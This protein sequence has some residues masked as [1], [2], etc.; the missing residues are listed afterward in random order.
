MAKQDLVVKLLLDSG[1][2]GNDIREAERKAKDFSDNM[3]SAG[4]TVG[5]FGNEL[6]LATGVLGK[7]G[8]MLTG[9]GAVVAA[10]GA[11]KSIMESTNESSM[12]FKSSIAGFE[13]VLSTFQQSLANF[14]FSTWLNGM[15]EVFRRHKEWKQ[16]QMEKELSGI[17][18]NALITRDEARIKEL[19]VKFNYAAS[20]SEREK[21]KK[22]ALGVVGEMRKVADNFG[23]AVSDGLISAIERL[24]PKLKEGG[25]TGEKADSLIWEALKK[26]NDRSYG[27][28]I[29]L[30]KQTAGEI[31]N[32][33]HILSWRGG[34]ELQTLR[35]NNIGGGNDVIIAEYEKIR[36]NKDF[37]RQR[38]TELIDSN[39]ELFFINAI[40]KMVAKEL[41]AE[42]SDMMNA[43]QQGKKADELENTILKWN[44]STG[45]GTSGNTKQTN[46]T[47]QTKTNAKLEPI[48]GSFADKQKEL[49]ELKRQ[50]DEDVVFESEKWKQ[51]TES[52]IIAEEALKKMLETQKQ[53]ENTDIINEDSIGYIQQQIAELERLR[54]TLSV[55]SEAWK[56][57]T[58]SLN[59]YLKKL[60][61]LKQS[62]KE[63]ENK[64][65]STENKEVKKY[66]DLNI[67]VGA[68]I[69]ILNGLS[70]AFSSAEDESIKSMGQITDVIS[71]LA[72]GFMDYISIKQA[73]AAS[74]AAASA[75]G[76]PFPYNLAA[77][78]VA[79]GTVMSIFAK[80]KQMSAGKYAEGGIVGGTS[81]SGD[82]LF[83]MVNS[84]EMILNKRQQGNLAN[85]LG[86]GGQVEFH[87]SGDSLV[88]VLN[89]KQRKTHLTR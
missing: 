10:V 79:V 61:E 15:D 63:Y 59:E 74:N 6:G 53:Y 76:L 9:A 25:I 8:G 87:I 3:K 30:Y 34:L 21:Y 67:A 50:R 7:L 26:Y 84:G 2:F 39:Q 89:N 31:D 46:Q 81:Y 32:I 52:I 37:Y 45:G 60:E 23:S 75:S 51:L 47:N 13:G 29:G 43:I 12:K 16:L 57:A 4:K 66:K 70:D 28:V 86:G 27:E 72:S 44:T 88:G 78:G 11:F 55:G 77:I 56:A 1:A 17:A 68:S 38:Q 64:E 41:S 19:E 62:Q 24:D 35:N 73:V 33:E 58:A 83:A 48:V 18:T 36:G 5:D 54:N 69:S 40:Y 82:K 85:M 71:T 20:D 80:I 14:D 65:K 42:I 49:A 22:E